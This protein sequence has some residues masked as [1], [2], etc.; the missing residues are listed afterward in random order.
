MMM[1]PLLI[2]AIVTTVLSSPLDRAVLRRGDTDY[3]QYPPLQEL[4]EEPEYDGLYNADDLLSLYPSQFYQDPLEAEPGMESLQEDEEARERMAVEPVLYRSILGN[5]VGLAV[6]ED[7]LPWYSDN[8]DSVDV[9]PEQLEADRRQNYLDQPEEDEGAAGYLGW[10]YLDPASYQEQEENLEQELHAVQKEKRSS[11]NPEGYKLLQK[12]A[13]SARKSTKKPTASSTTAKPEAAAVEPAAA[14]APKLMTPEKRGMPETPI[15][16]PGSAS[17]PRFSS[18][19]EEARPKRS[20]QRPVPF[21]SAML[22]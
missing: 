5:R 8:V 17:D 20:L 1:S 18:L 9:W 14:A 19:P 7:E 15:L 4:L 16:R 11:E 22:R 10:S 13:I 2:L 21:S 12:P 6:P 3:H